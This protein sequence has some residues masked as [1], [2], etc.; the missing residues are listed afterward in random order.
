MIAGGAVSN[1]SRQGAVAMRIGAL[2]PSDRERVAAVVRAT[3]VFRDDEVAIAME[4]FDET[5]GAAKPRRPAADDYQ[6]VG[7]FGTDD[8]LLGYACYGLT[9]GTVG[10]WDVYWIA[11]DPAMHGAGIGTALMLEVERRLLAERARLVVVETSSRS[12]YAPTRRFYE[13]L[14]YEEAA[15]VAGFYAP[16]DDRIIFVK[17]FQ[18]LVDGPGAGH[19]E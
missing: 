15:R 11:V 18:G 6:F 19:H 10:T 9:P 3:R 17:R 8:V 4:L 14:G 5:F 2:R 16:G 7:A 13:R 1:L 12:D